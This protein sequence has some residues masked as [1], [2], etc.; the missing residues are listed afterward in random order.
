MLRIIQLF[1]ALGTAQLGEFKAHTGRRVAFSGLLAFFGL[2][3][4]GFGLAAVTVALAAQLGTL[5][6]LL[7]MAGL[8]LLG[9]VVVMILMNIAERK[10]RVVAMERD[11][12]RGR[13]RQLALMTVVGGASGGRPGIGKMIGLGVV[14][15]AG[16]LAVSNARKNQRRD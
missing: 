10:H 11:E 15:L 4:L 2:I 9:C 6:A 14:G 5:Y 12:L 16:I 13:L 7:I 1:I 3:V 8:G